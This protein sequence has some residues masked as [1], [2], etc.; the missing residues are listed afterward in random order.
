G[1]ADL[2]PWLDHLERL[3]EATDRQAAYVKMLCEVVPEIFDGEVQLT[4]TLKIA[5]L[6][7]HRLADRDLAREYYQ[8]VLELRSDDKQA[9]IALESLYEESGDA[10]SLLD[11]LERRVEAAD[12]DDER[13]Q[14]LF[15]RARLLAEV[16]GDKARAIDVY[17]AILDLDLDRQAIEALEGLYADEQRWSDL[18]ELYQRE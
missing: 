6:A 5:E 2:K 18:V 14:L 11:V 7:R 10:A 8:K 17:V 15:R 9:L 12:D 13:K 3:A 4:V 16:I 1:H